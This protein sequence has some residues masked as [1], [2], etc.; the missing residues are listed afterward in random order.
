MADQIL[1][2]RDESAVEFDLGVTTPEG[3][4]AI[5][6]HD[7]SVHATLNKRF[8]A[9]QG[10]AQAISA[11]GN[12]DLVT[13]TSGK[14]IR[15]K[16]VAFSAPEGNGAE[17][18]VTIKIG[19]DIL[20]MWPLGASCA[21]SHGAVREGAVDEPLTINLSTAQTVYVNYEYEEF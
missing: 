5:R 13:P 14:A 4:V 8:G 20:Y 16:W 3:N 10:T 9:P 1:R 11:S 17:V 12:T 15:L 2:V 19:T 7:E 18:I 6:N 21:F